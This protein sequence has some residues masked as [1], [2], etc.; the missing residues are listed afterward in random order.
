MRQSSNIHLFPWDS[1]TENN[2]NTYFIDGPHRILIDPGYD[3]FFGHVERS[4]DGLGVRLDTID[5]VLLTHSHP[6]HMEAVAR[7]QGLATQVAMHAAEWKF[8]EEQ[9]R[10]LAALFGYDPSQFPPDALLEEG[11]F[12]LADRRFQIYHTPGH[13][14]GSICLYW[15]EEEALFT[16]DLVFKEGFGRV[17]FPGGDGYRIKESIRRMAA[18]DVAL[19]LPG[20]GEPVIGEAAVRE[21][22]DQIIEFYFDFIE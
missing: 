21:N 5:Q 15:P 17:D 14:P 19:L 3:R 16:G 6:D 7:F 11:L 20:H 22:F 9:G 8:V 4:L 2:C 18:L 13:T 10:Y 12:Q 1:M